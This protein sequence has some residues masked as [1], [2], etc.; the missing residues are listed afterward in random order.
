MKSLY[1]WLPDHVDTR[2]R[3]LGWLSLIGQLLLIATGGA[4]RLTGSG[5]GCPTW[6]KC[7]AGSLINT[8]Q[9]GIHGIIEFTN[10]M[11][12]VALVIV[13]IVAFLFVVRMFRTRRDLFWITFW[14]GMSIPAQAVIGGLT[15][16]SK[17]DPYVVGVHFVVSILLVAGS[18]FL[19][20]RIHAVPGARTPAVP[21]WYALIAWITAFFVTITILVG[22]LTT[23]SGPHAGDGHARR[24]GLNSELLQHIH[25][26]PAYVTFG[27]TIVLVT[28]ALTLGLTTVRRYALWL[29]VIE[30]V[31]IAVG[32]LQANSGLPGY[33]VGTHMVLAGLLAAVMTAAVLNLERPV[34]S[35]TGGASR[36]APSRG[37]DRSAAAG[38]S[39]RPERA[40][41]DR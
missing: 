39:R 10:R 33:L 9:M 37:R 27:L 28:A 8:P 22:I 41:S 1:R 5:L 30:F 3:V 13:V 20:V 14:L 23:G 19:V 38:R 25:S 6:P 26:I 12:S 11:L 7:T 31:Q 36:G 29:L 4:V 35:P 40:T 32:L 18:A 34:A 16:L 15:V 24:N 21:G 2:V 17:L